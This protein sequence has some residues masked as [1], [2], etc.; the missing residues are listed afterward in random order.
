MYVEEKD[1]SEQ[2]LKL[3]DP[4]IERHVDEVEEKD[5]SEQGLKLHF[6]NKMMVKEPS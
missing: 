5:P 4:E 3:G 6:C 2:G 1:P